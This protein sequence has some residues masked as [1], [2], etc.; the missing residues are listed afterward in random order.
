MEKR[1]VL[2]ETIHQEKKEAF[3][4]E[5][6]ISPDLTS[7]LLQRGIESFQDAKTFFRPS[8]NHLHDPFLMKNMD[9]AVNRLCDA[10]FSQEKIL[11]YGDY[12]VD[13]TTSVSLVH[14]FLSKFLRHCW[15][16]HQQVL[17]CQI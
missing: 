6:N 15:C 13:G 12:D 2:N 14:G 16:Y 9:T 1:W 5:L 8:L 3:S 17:I 4:K 10:I 7:L 11:I